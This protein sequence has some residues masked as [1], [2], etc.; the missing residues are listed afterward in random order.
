MCAFHRT[1]RLE[2]RPGECTAAYFNM[3]WIIDRYEI[4][5]LCQW[6]GLECIVDGTFVDDLESPLWKIEQ[7]FNAS[8]DLNSTGLITI[9]TIE[10]PLVQS[11]QPMYHYHPPIA[12]D[13]EPAFQLDLPVHLR[14]GAQGMNYIAPSPVLSLLAAAILCLVYLTVTIIAKG[15]SKNKK[16]S[17]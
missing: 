12:S 13:C 16:C 4:K 5:R 11:T 7:M 15:K 8:S 9:V 17:V 2:G 14:Y 10:C 6:Q 1:V 3:S